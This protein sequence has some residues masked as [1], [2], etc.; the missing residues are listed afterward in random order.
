MS[1]RHVVPV[2]DNE[3][4]VFHLVEERCSESNAYLLV[5]QLNLERTEHVF[6][7]YGSGLH[8]LISYSL[9]RLQPSTSA[10]PRRVGCPVSCTRKDRAWHGGPRQ[11][12]QF[13][14]SSWP[15]S[16]VSVWRLVCSPL[17]WR[18]D[19]GI[20]PTRSPW[21]VSLEYVWPVCAVRRGLWHASLYAA[22]PV[23]ADYW[24]SLS[25]EK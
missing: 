2:R 4:V 15:W 5:T 17:S 10:V 19:L 18:R 8:R 25:L 14:S 20:A 24:L 1:A 9:R 16:A 11:A 12:G 3:C 6:V 23:V 21:E 7:V 13:C 22:A